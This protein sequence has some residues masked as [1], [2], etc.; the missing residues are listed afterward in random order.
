RR[1]D[2]RHH[3]RRVGRPRL[4][5][6]GAGATA[7][8]AR[9][10]VFWAGGPGH[11]AAGGGVGWSMLPVV[12]HSIQRSLGIKRTIWQKILPAATIAISYIPAIVYIGL[13]A[14]IPAAHRPDDLL[15]R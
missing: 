5:A 8:V 11:T 13:G 15:P 6:A 7:A 12:K 4:A 2:A 10:R 1:P 9:G 3:P 14:L